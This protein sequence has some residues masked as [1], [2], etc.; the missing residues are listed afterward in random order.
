MNRNVF[1]ALLICVFSLSVLRADWV[2]I[3]NKETYK[4]NPEVTLISDD[5]N[6]T[7]F[8]IDISGFDISEV[9]TEGKTYQLVDLLAESFTLDEGFPELPYIAKVLAVPDRAAISVEVINTGDVQTFHNIYLPPARESWI[10]SQPES[11][12][13]ENFMAY[14]SSEVYPQQIVKV[15]PPSIFRD[16]RIARISV[17]PVRY[18]PAKKE[19]Q[20][21]S[22]ITVRINYGAGEAVNPKTTPRRKI[23]PSFGKLYRSFIFNYQ[24]V[25][26]NYYG[27]EEE[28]RELMLC[29]MPDEFTESF[30]PYANWNRQSGTDIH[31]TKFSDIGATA[32][33]PQ[34]IKDHVADAYHNWPDPPTYVLLVGDDGVFP[35]KI[36]VYPDYSFPNE[37]YF[38]EIDG[39]DHFPEAM[40]GRFTNQGDYRMQ[41]MIKK[42]MMYEKTPYVAEFEWFKKGICCS[43]NEF[44]SQ[45]QT[46]RFA[47]ERML[48][49]GGFLSVDTMMSDGY[50][51]G[52]NCTYDV[53]DVMNAINDGRSYLNYRGEG[54]SSGWYANCYDFYTDNVNNLNNGE[55]FTFVT[56]IGCGV[57]MFDTYGGNCFGEAWI[58][59]GSLDEPRG[60]VAFVGPTSNTHTTYNNKI[61]KGIYEGMFV[62]GM[63]TPGQALLR[64]K[65]YMYN[66]FG[67]DSWVEYHYRVY[68]ILGDPSL[69]IWKDVPKNVHVDYPESITVGNTPL[70]VTITF[71][72]SGEPVAN[73]ELC[74]TGNELFVKGTSDADGK[75]Y[76]DVMTEIPEMLTVTARGGNVYPYQGT[77]D[78]TQPGEMVQPFDE[79]VIVDIDGNT[80]GLVNPNEN[81]NIT[82]TLKN[83]GTQTA[84]NIQATLST[85]TPDFVEIV[86]TTPVDFGN[87]NSGGSNTGNPFQFFVKPGCQ[88]G[89]FVN[90]HLHVSSSTSTWDYDYQAEVFGCKL[91]DKNFMVVDDG[92]PAMNYRMDPGE[93]VKLLFSIENIG[94]DIA[95]DIVAVLSSND[96]YITVDDP[97]GSFESLAVYDIS[98][99]SEDYFEVSVDPSCP[100]EYWAQFTLQ[101]NTQNG[102]YPYEINLEL[103]IPV[104]MLIPT[105]YTGPD[106]YGYYAYS[107][108]DSFFEQR[109]EYDWFELEGIG[110]YI[111]VPNI[112]DFT[113]TVNL[114]FTFRYYGVDYDQVRISTDGWLAL[115]SGNQTAPFNTG[116]PNNDNVNCMIAPFWDDLYDDHF[117]EGEILY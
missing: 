72:A 87:L 21:V 48:E 13:I 40:I 54:W 116:L 99:N 44:P 29:I 1:F 59:L 4:T 11:Q 84:S 111:Y 82:Y 9:I 74:I 22:S 91:V 115:G 96:Q 12:Y 24:N 80:D 94:E 109:P 57:A 64:G 34:T 61:D 110:S 89:Q 68:C 83:Y 23:A 117:I 15:E 8:K 105:S 6:S 20:V 46:K 107:S 62:E 3:D 31:I 27:G 76:I 35:V 113:Q 28:G 106:A 39:N 25:L 18:I 10:E 55:M 90:L 60:G 81:C 71:T 79:P 49:D 41:V 78:V 67:S 32:Y 97:N 33:N 104:A 47:A 108:D 7:V 16:F 19:L 30:Q 2:P 38:V 63:D 88:V 98:V 77:M 95:P 112:S 65:T 45:V 114:P 58:Q 17:F 70:E 43:N 93:T 92:S 73:A 85:T 52:Y 42:F 69:H 75:F 66:V 100:T 37:D 26:D 102:N 56:S 50:W 86:T 103:N 14:Q 101:L 36:I 51:G 5:N 53:Q